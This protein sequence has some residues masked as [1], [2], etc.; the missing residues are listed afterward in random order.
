MAADVDEERI[1]IDGREIQGLAKELTD[2]WRPV[3]AQ[4]QAFKEAYNGATHVHLTMLDRSEENGVPNLA[5]QGATQ[6]A[7][8]IASE[9]PNPTVPPIRSGKS[10]GKEKAEKT[11]SALL[12]WWDK[13]HMRALLLQRALYLPSYGMSPVV[14]TPDTSRGF[15]RWE[16]RD[17]LTALISPMSAG[18]LVPDIAIFR[19]TRSLSWLRSRFPD[20]VRQ[21]D[22]GPSPKA[23][24]IY[25]VLEY[26]DAKERV[27][28]CLGRQA[29][30]TTWGAPTN[31]SSVVLAR[32][33]TRRS[34][35]VCPQRY[36]LDRILGHFDG[37]LG[38]SRAEARLFALQQIAVEKSIFAEPW[39]EGDNP[40]VVKKADAITGDVGVVKG[41]RLHFD[42]PDAG[43]SAMPMIN[44]LH[45]YQREAASMP[46]QWGGEQP[47]NV[48]TG[49]AAGDLISASIAPYVAEYQRSLAES[50]EE[51][52]TIALEEAKEHW[53]ETTRTFFLE[54]KNAAQGDYTPKDTFATTEVRVSHSHPGRS[55]QEVTVEIGQLMGLDV[56]SADTARRQ[57]PLVKDPDGEARKV[58]I[59]SIDMAGISAIQQQAAS[60]QIPPADLAFIKK[61]IAAGAT[62]EDAIEEAQER[63]QTRQATS[64][65][66]G[67]PEGPV[68]PASPEAQPGLAAPGMGAEA[69]A[70]PGNGTEAADLTQLLNQARTTRLSMTA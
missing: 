30:E 42:R 54:G 70:I 14:V 23:T 24:D 44:A 69:G 39:L 60:G 45:G 31:P 12:W 67:E 3:H 40:Q 21:L 22:C 51:E 4:M 61:R 5:Q 34:G 2:H 25:E 35:V 13:N 53:G 66:P 52:S 58:L 38:M 11:R 43:F 65:A 64:G 18:Q 19:F 15:A 6:L 20:E 29:R 8:A 63:A 41:G 17:P 46:S 36:T 55:E 26:H 37:I 9:V 10:D 48:R 47:A 68:D 28:L 57:H 50:M 49:R 56:I 27:L 1:V 62:W 59:Q 32:A 33:K 7:L 16:V